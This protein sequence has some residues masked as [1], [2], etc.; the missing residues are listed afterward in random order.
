MPRRPGAAGRTRRATL[1]PSFYTPAAARSRAGGAAITMAPDHDAAAEERGG[2]EVANVLRHD[3]IHAE[4]EHLVE[5]AVVEAAVPSHRDER[6]A[7]DPRNR[8]GVEGVD[9]TL[10]VTLEIP[11]RREPFQVA[12]DRHVRDAVQRVEANAVQA[13]QFALPVSFE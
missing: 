2:I 11:R 4:V 10:H 7:H 6:P 1:R 8:G 9:Q 13:E 5:V 3:P 12:A